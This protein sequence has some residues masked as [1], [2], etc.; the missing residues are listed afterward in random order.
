MDCSSL[1]T[2]NLPAQI[3]LKLPT[4]ETVAVPCSMPPIVIIPAMT[5][6]EV[7]TIVSQSPLAAVSA[8]PVKLMTSLVSS[9]PSVP[10]H[11]QEPLGSPVVVSSGSLTGTDSQP[12]AA[13]D[14]PESGLTALGIA[15]S[16]REV[17]L[18][19]VV[20]V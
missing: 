3:M 16:T 19:S 7:G 9:Q 14:L 18:S 12:G 15:A 6:T 5:S 11:L 4:G 10:L 20:F 2:V 17:G 13:F 8:A 1:N